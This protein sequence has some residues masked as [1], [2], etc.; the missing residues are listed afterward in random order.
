[1]R[2]IA[3]TLSK[4]GV[5]KTTTALNLAHGLAMTGE[6][7]LLVDADTQGQAAAALGAAPERGFA[8]IL[9]GNAPPD[10]ALT[11]VRK[12]LSLLAGGQQLAA[13]KG[14]IAGRGDGG[15]YAVSDALD[16]LEANYDYC[17]V[18]TAPGWDQL[19]VSVLFFA[20]EVIAPVALDAM[21]LQGLAQ[22]VKSIEPVKR[23]HTLSLA[24]L[25]TFF[26]RRV[27]KS[28]EILG[29]LKKHFKANMLEAIRYNVRLAEAPGY[30]KTIFEFDKNSPGAIDY[31]KLV[32]H[33]RN[34]AS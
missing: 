32:E 16:S 3:V 19:T 2:K 21:A 29:Q 5:G 17:I 33:I 27:K 23:H 30:G 26:D 20:A 4:G 12:N 10:D 13:A 11:V 28:E 7:V 15:V 1:M 31:A 22:F 25:P 6:R 24:I 18:D 14:V 9:S 34:G 8:N